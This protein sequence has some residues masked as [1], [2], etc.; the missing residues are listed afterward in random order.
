M[1]EFLC[2]KFIIKLMKINEIDRT[3]YPFTNKCTKSV[4]VNLINNYK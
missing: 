1:R 4:D 3:P 2:V